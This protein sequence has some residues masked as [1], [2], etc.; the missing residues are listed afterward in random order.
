MAIFTLQHVFLFQIRDDLLNTSVIEAEIPL[1]EVKNPCRT[2][3][4]P[5]QTATIRNGLSVRSAAEVPPSTVFW[6][7]VPLLGFLWH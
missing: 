7:L 1:S 3:L 2:V 6:T 4:I 5:P